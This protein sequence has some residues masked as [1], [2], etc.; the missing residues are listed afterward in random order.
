MTT[1][2]MI[3]VDPL[4]QDPVELPRIEHDD[5]IQQLASPVMPTVLVSLTRTGIGI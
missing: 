5:F 4:T 1:V 3:V 2:L